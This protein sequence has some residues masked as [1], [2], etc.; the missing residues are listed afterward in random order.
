MGAVP[1]FAP[2]RLGD[3][4]RRDPGRPRGFERQ[5][6]DDRKL[7]QRERKQGIPNWAIIAF[8]LFVAAFVFT[9]LIC[10]G[11]ALIRVAGVGGPTRAGRESRRASTATPA[12]VS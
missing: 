6:G 4:G 11:A 2:G 8:G 7:L 9:L 10:A 5:L 3:P 1:V 12:P